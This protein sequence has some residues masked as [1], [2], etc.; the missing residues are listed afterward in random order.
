MMR[1]LWMSLLVSFAVACGG[2][3]TAPGFGA[4]GDKQGEPGYPGSTGGGSGEGSAP[5]IVSL[6]VVLDDFGSEGYVL[7]IDVEYTDAD[8]DVYDADADSGGTL[9]MSVSG[10]G[11]EAQDV[12]ASIGSATG[13]ATEAYIDPETGNVVS[14]LSSIDPDIAYTVDVTLV[15]MAGNASETVQGSY[16]P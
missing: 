11:S 1:G 5:E 6:D 7:I 15:D 13:G 4:G 8:D 16:T 10:E 9:Q 12:S 14:A 3:T 2:G